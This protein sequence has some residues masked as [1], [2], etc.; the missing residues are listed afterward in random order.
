MTDPTLHATLPPSGADVWVKCTGAPKMWTQFP[1][2]EDTSASMEGTAAHWVVA[3]LTAGRATPIGTLAPNGIAVTQEMREGAEM[4]CDSFPEEQFLPGG[5]LMV[6]SRVS[7]PSIHAQCWGTPDARYISDSC[8]H[9]IDYKYGFGHVD[10]FENWQGVAYIAGVLDLHPQF[11]DDSMMF[12]FTIVQ[13]RCYEAGGPVRTWRGKVSDLRA[14]IEVLRIAA[15]QAMSDAAILTTGPQCRYCSAVVSCPA[16]QRATSSALAVSQAVT[17]SPMTPESLSMMLRYVSDA[18]DTLK[19]MQGGLTVEAEALIRSGKRVPGFGLEAG[20]GKTEWS[21]PIEEVVA[22]GAVLGVDISKSGVLTPIQAAALFKTK[23][24]DDGVIKA[25]SSST[26][27]ALKL[28]QTDESVM[29][30]VFGG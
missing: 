11:N 26:S 8:I 2:R 1:Q 30:R 25:Y 15:E 5:S 20:R 19:A 18:I 21:A 23:G 10:E 29:R 28:V 17:P 3:E 22:L 12:E 24:V 4:F 27:G 16:A 13:P 14:R 7:C 6:E 9:V